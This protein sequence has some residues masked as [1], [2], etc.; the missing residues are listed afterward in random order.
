MAMH[1][2]VDYTNKLNST[3]TKDVNIAPIEATTTSTHAYSVGDKFML[4]GTLYRT[5]VNIA[6]GD[7]IVPGAEGASGVN[8]TATTVVDEMGGGSAGHTIENSAGTDMTARS[9]LQFVNST[10]TD[11]STNDRTIVAPNNI[12]TTTTDPGEGS[13]LATNCLLFVIEE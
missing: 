1:D 5:T 4:N 10:V 3:F 8:A 12:T 6:I 11:D 13:S 2:I 7:T 9:N